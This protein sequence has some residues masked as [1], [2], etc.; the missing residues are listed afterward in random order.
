MLLFL[1]QYWDSPI[2][3]EEEYLYNHL[4]GHIKSVFRIDPLQVYGFHAV[5]AII[6]INFALS[7]NGIL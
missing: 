4:I 1:N 7:D 3:T 6:L 2:K 5:S